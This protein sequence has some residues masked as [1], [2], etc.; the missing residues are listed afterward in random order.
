VTSALFGSQDDGARRSLVLAGG[1]MRVA[2]QAGVLAA[3]EQAGLRF[4]HVD[5]SSGGTMNLSMLLTGQDSEEIGQR[6][7]TLRQ[8]DFSSLLPWRDYARSLR[9]PALGGA[10]GLREKVF[11][12]LGIDVAG[13]PGAEHRIDDEIR[14]RGRRGRECRA[15]RRWQRGILRGESIRTGAIRAVGEGALP[16]GAARPAAS[17]RRRAASADDS[18]AT[19]PSRVYFLPSREFSAGC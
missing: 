6:W 14:L 18:L 17:G 13:Q 12:H 1:G 3:L 10:R 19:A 4:H 15:Q 7:R 9:W 11:P 8:R 2:Y 5:G 16:I